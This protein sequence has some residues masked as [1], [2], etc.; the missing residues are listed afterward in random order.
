MLHR[1]LDDINA[2]AADNL[3]GAP[4]TLEAFTQVDWPSGTLFTR[5][6]LEAARAGRTHNTD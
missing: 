4:D 5:E 1:L 6:Q 2:P 3:S